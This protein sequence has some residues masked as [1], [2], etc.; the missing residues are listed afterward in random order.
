[1]LLHSVFPPRRR[2]EQHQ[3]GEDLQ[4]PGQHVEGEDDLAQ[5]RK[6]AVVAG[7]AHHVQAG[8][9]VV[10]AGQHRRQVRLHRELVHR[11]Q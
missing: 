1:M 8:A 7:G 6:G 3:H 4:P 2:D 10:D 11:D 5:R 9:D